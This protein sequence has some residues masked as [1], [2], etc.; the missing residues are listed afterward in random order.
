MDGRSPLLAIEVHV[1][2]AFLHCARSFL[3][4]QLWDPEHFMPRDRMPSL[5]RM[6]ADQTRLADRS[7]TEHQN[8]IEAGERTLAQANRCLY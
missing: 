2:E 1:E 8:L 3:R 7:D 4:A 5:S 6:I